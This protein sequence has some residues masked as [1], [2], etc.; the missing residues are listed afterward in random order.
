MDSKIH[1][2]YEKKNPKNINKTA[3]VNNISQVVIQ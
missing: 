1:V 2:D 3:Y